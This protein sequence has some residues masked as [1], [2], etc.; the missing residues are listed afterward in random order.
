MLI[1]EHRSCDGAGLDKR[2][3]TGSRDPVLFYD[4]IASKDDAAEQ[5]EVAEEVVDLVKNYLLK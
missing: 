2:F 5:I 1:R 3:G 4:R